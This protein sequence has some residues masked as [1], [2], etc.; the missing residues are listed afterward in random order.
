MRD[1][2]AFNII[3]VPA[4]EICTESFK[5]TE[6]VIIT[7]FLNQVNCCIGYQ[8]SLQIT[9]TIAVTCRSDKDLSKERLELTLDFTI[10]CEDTEVVE[11]ERTFTK[12][13][14]LFS[15]HI[16]ILISTSCGSDS[17]D[18]NLVGLLKPD[19][20]LDDEFTSHQVVTS[21]RFKN[22][23]VKILDQLTTIQEHEI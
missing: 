18:F 9:S 21:F 14:H 4:N 17:I 13:T 11:P 20:I 16:T 7:I 12:I 6:V 10:D 23:V 1:D 19:K 8:G 3:F 5:S 2:D 15:G 22:G